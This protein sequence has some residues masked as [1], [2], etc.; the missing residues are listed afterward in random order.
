MKLSDNKIEKLQE[1]YKN[2]VDEI[3]NVEDMKRWSCRKTISSK[4][5]ESTRTNEARIREAIEESD[6][7]IEEGERVYVFFKNDESLSLVDNF[8]GHDYNKERLLRKAFNTVMRFETLLP[9]KEVFVNY[10]KKSEQI[11]LGILEKKPRKTKTK[12]DGT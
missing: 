12:V 1:I 4:T 10:S 6:D 11:K 2:Y 5:M 9:V 7:K 3:L 8:D